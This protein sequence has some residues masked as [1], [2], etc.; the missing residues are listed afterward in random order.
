MRFKVLVGLQ[1]AAPAQFLIRRAWAA[2]LACAA[3]KHGTASSAAA[4]DDAMCFAVPP[5]AAQGEQPHLEDDAQAEPLL[6]EPAAMDID[7]SC[8]D[9]LHVEP[10]AGIAEPASRSAS[11]EVAEAERSHAESSSL[12][13]A[14]SNISQTLVPAWR[15]LPALPVCWKEPVSKAAILEPV[16]AGRQMPATLLDRKVRAVLAI[17]V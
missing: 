6:D 14:Q 2:W 10:E 16:P 4:P 15:C 5:D 7:T 11:A 1:Q 8:Q 3:E 17:K 13:S 9:R 12:A